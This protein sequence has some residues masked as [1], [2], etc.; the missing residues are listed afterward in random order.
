[1]PARQ[2]LRVVSTVF[3]AAASQEPANKM[4]ALPEPPVPS[5]VVQEAPVLRVPEVV[6]PDLVY[7]PPVI[8]DFSVTSCLCHV[9]VFICR[10]S[11]YLVSP[12]CVLLPCKFPVYI[13]LYVSVVYC[14][15]LLYVSFFFYFKYLFFSYFVTLFI[16]MKCILLH[17]DLFPCLV[18]ALL[19]QN[20][21]I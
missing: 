5:P 3:V 15:S 13:S 4:P 21:S 6:L 8:L 1:M 11:C 14:Q 16:F 10:F 18:C 7:V 20:V 9:F 12:R 17:V 2:T 19:L